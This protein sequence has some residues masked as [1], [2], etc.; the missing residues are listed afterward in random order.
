[1]A[2]HLKA[3]IPILRMFDVAKTREFYVQYLGFTLEFEHRYYDGAPLFMA[4]K[5]DRVML[6]L[7]EHHGDGN[8]GAHVLLEMTGV[9]ELHRELSEKKY[10]YMNPGIQTQE[11]G[12]REVCV[13]D[14]AG[15][16]VIFS[17]RQEKAES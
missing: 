10:A 7:S 16:Y 5:R 14:P 8:P 17:E 2:V 13:I 11:W 9:D 4:V 6:F 1:V 12:R 15:N 3:T